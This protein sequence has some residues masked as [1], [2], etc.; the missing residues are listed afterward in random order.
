MY[1]CARC[2]AEFFTRT[3]FIKRRTSTHTRALGYAYPGMRHTVRSTR[4]P[5]PR[6]GRAVAR[7]RAG[8]GSVSGRRSAQAAPRRSRAPGAAG[9]QE[10]KWLARLFLR[11]LK[12]GAES[13]VNTDPRKL[14]LVKL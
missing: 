6:R 5:R 13:W 11:D 14:T 9:R 7:G 3:D 2:S 8:G 4:P 10:A 12:I 1:T